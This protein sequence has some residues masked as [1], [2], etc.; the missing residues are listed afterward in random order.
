MTNVAVDVLLVLGVA[1][2]LACVAGVV[3][4][5]NTYDRLH[6]VAAATTVPSFLILAAVLCREHFQ[7]GG[8]QAIVAVGLM[9]SMFPVLLT[10]TARAARRIDEGDE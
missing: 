3:V 10:A 8:I 5:R 1:T 2:E 9:F 7:G 6:Y 4:M